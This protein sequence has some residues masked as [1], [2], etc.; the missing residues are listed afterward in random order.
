MI[1]TTKTLDW[2]KYLKTAAQVVSEGIVMLKNE[3]QALPL[4]PDVLHWGSKP[5]EKETGSGNERMC[6]TWT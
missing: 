6:R 4:F 2:D 3:H 5:G 1:Q